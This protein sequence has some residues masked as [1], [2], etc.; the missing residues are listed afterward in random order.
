MLSAARPAA[1]IDLTP[2]SPPANLVWTSAGMTV[3][4]SWGASTDDVGVVAYDFYY[5]SYFIGSTADTVATLIGFRTGTPYDFTVKA[6][7]AAG[8]LSS[9]SNR[10]T[11]LLTPSQDTTPPTAPTNVTASN[12]TDSTVTLRWTASI[13]DVGVVVYQ[14]YAGAALVGT[15]PMGSSATLSSLSPGTTYSFTVTAWDAAG[16]A[17]PASAQLSVKT[18]GGGRAVPVASAAALRAALAAA[19]PGD[20][21]QLADGTYSGRFTLTDKHGTASQPIAVTGGVGAVLDGGDPAS[22]YGFNLVGCSWVRLTGFS[23]TRSQKAIVAN[24]TT[25]SVFDGLYLHHIGDE[26]VALRNFSTDNVVQ[27]C[28]ITETGLY[29]PQYGEGVYI[30][31]WNG[32]WGSVSGGLPDASDRNQV[33]DNAFGPN[34][35]AEHIDIKEGTHDGVVR[36]N[37]FDGRGISGQNYADSFVDAQGNGYL[38]EGNDGA[39]SSEAGTVFADAYQTHIMLDGWGCGNVFRANTSALNGLA[40]YGFNIQE[41]AT[42]CA[43]NL[44]VVYDSNTATGTT[45][46]L[47]NVPLTH[48]PGQ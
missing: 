19:L 48:D 13:D 42:R 29:E 6:R 41:N 43:G 10:I 32:N 36:G 38:I 25:F 14:I 46:G 37:H 27:R 5:G 21:I 45:G 39:V 33:V 3:T 15:T 44:N 28:L 35:R 11:V 16:N 7:D 20:V 18:T 23:I 9:A 24:K 40:K 1:A 17:S 2:P 30:G 47:A 22:G 34:V 31:T 8:N 12:V 26:A 4:M